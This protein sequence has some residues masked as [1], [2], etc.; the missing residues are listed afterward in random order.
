MK[1][2]QLDNNSWVFI[3]NQHENLISLNNQEYYA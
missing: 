3:R 2:I 1:V